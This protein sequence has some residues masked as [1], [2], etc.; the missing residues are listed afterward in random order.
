[1]VE[2]GG[3]LI[4]LCGLPASGKTTVAELLNRRMDGV[5][6]VSSDYLRSK[7]GSS[8]IWSRMAHEVRAGL[9][10][11]RTV[12]V[13]ATNYSSA[14]RERYVSISREMALPHLV[15]YLRA[16]MPTLVERNRERKERIPTGAIGHLARLFE[17]PGGDDTIRIDTE[18]SQ[19]EQAA[20]TIIDRKAEIAADSIS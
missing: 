2:S 4:V 8:R 15:A 18:Q 5:Q 11:G 3:F 1:M 19:P 13:D 17:A 6:I 7:G 14:H 12:I 9:S 10:A 16:G 20:V